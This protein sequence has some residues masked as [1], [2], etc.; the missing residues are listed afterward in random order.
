MEGVISEGLIPEV[1]VDFLSHDSDIR[2]TQPHSE[3]NSPFVLAT[4]WEKN[5]VKINYNVMIPL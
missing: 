5:H 2:D 4:L 3:N 1:K